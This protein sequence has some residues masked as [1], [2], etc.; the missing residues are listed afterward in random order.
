MSGSPLVSVVIPT[1]NRANV[2]TRAIRSVLSQ[3]YPN[4]EIIVVDDGSEDGTAIALS[5]FNDIRI[6][7][8]CNRGVSA[9]RNAGIA[10]S[11]GELIAFLDSDDEWRPDKIRKQVLRYSNAKPEFVCHSNELWMR[12]EKV[13]PQKGIHSKQGGLFF[14]R[15][16]QR[17]LISPS[18]VIISRVLLD[19]VGWFDEDLKA[20]EDYD[21][22]LRIT[23]FHQV[24]FVD[25]QLLIKHAGE[26]NQLSVTT[27]AIDRYRVKALE[28]ILDN[29]LLPDAYRAAARRAL[30][31]KSTIL[32]NGFLKR[33]KPAEAKLYDELARKHSINISTPG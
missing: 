30:M 23:A 26:R 17:C 9:A 13:V 18:A 15:A 31:E 27:T 22:W 11:K 10:M 12:G 20:A 7:S 32:S 8:Q 19:T 3:T 6:I 16:V 28:K 25:E 1:Y 5:H 21:L 29:P 14:T 24:D 4:L 33:G 2:V